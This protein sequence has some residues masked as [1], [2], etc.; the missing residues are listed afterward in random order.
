M[1]LQADMQLQQKNTCAFLQCITI[2]LFLIRNNRR[3]QE[4]E[5]PMPPQHTALALL[6]HPKAL[7]LFALAWLATGLSS[8]AHADNVQWSLGVNSSGYYAPQPGV[9]LQIGNNHRPYHQPPPQVIVVQ[10]QAPVY[11]APAPIYVTPAPVYQP[12]RGHSHRQP[13]RHGHRGHHPHRQHHR[14]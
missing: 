11:M 8:A 5:I 3:L 6:R 13:P 4:P 10:P 7:L 2:H 12:G 14:H 1:A 9:S